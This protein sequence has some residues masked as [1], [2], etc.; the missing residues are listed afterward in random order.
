MGIGPYAI[1]VTLMDH[2]NDKTTVSLTLDDTNS[3]YLTNGF[4]NLNNTDEP[5][6]N[7]WADRAD[8]MVVRTGANYAP[9]DVVVLLDQADVH[10]GKTW[11]WDPANPAW[12]A[13]KLV[14]GAFL[15]DLN[16]ADNGGCADQAA[17]ITFQS[18]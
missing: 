10:S 4:I 9:G 2:V 15:V 8:H 5:D 11:T 1:Q 18:S 6:G 14:G 17:A 7:T 12:G 13:T 16:D 3:E